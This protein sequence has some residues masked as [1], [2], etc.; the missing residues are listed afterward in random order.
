MLYP[1]NSK[2]YSN[3]ARVPPHRWG[4]KSVDKKTYEYVIRVIQKRA[5][6]IPVKYLAADLGVSHSTLRNWL[7]ALS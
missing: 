5:Q 7:G 4:C 3:S 2:L 1:E 6:V